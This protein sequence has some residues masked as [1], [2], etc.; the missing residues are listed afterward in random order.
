MDLILLSREK[1]F[2]SINNLIK[3][4][5]EYY[6]LWLCELQKWLREAHNID[7]IIKPWTGNLPNQKTYAAD[8]SIFN[9]NIHQK[10]MRVNSFEEALEIGLLCGLN[11]IK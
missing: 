7:I 2:M 9:S 4:N 1:G 10:C 8:V 5:A 6:Y 11:L 3:V